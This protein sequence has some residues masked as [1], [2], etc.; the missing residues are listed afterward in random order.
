MYFLDVAWSLT[1]D[2]FKCQSLNRANDFY[3]PPVRL[4][5]PQLASYFLLPYLPLG[6][7]LLSR[8]F[9]DPACLSERGWSV[10]PPCRKAVPIHPHSRISG[11]DTISLLRVLEAIGLINDDGV[12]AIPELKQCRS[13]WLRILRFNLCWRKGNVPALPTN[14]F[15]LPDIPTAEVVFANETKVADYCRTALQLSNCF[16]DL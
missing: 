11:C 9:L 14:S 1:M 12:F 7:R 10:F 13:L 5:N 6:T 15:S 8:N 16:V 3:H 2:D 4:L